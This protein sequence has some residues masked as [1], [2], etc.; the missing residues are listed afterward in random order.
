MLFNSS[1]PDRIQLLYMLRDQEER[2]RAS[3]ESRASILMAA[4]MLLLTGIGL[5][6]SDFS[7]ETPLLIKAT[8]CIPPLALAL[9]IFFSIKMLK[10]VPNEV[11]GTRLNLESRY[12]KETHQNLL[13][14]AEIAEHIEP[15]KISEPTESNGNQKPEERKWNHNVGKD[16]FIGDIKK[17]DR[18]QILE[19]LGSDVH[20][21]YCLS[22]WRYGQI[23][24][25]LKFLM[26][27]TASF[28]ILL[29]LHTFFVT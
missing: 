10:S 28:V 17:K 11:R 12:D 20:N 15:A 16:Q 6:V 4:D 21:L 19:M 8:A 14:Y 3:F 26:V 23:N 13:Y 27:G 24:H 22:H 7:A 25:A 1:E 2:R 9:S 18:S 29:I 5:I